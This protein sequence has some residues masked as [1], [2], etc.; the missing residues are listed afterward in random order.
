MVN[1]E[2]PTTIPSIEKRG[3]LA[4]LRQRAKELEEKDVELS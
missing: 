2:S 4:L 3:D 1:E